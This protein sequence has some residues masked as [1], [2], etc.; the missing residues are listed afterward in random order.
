MDTLH[1]TS[2]RRSADGDQP[3]HRVEL[4][5]PSG[6]TAVV[7]VVGEHDLSRA[8]ALRDALV[9]AAEQRSQVLVDFSRCTLLDSTGIALLLEAQLQVRAAEGRFV[10]VIPPEQRAVARVAELIRLAD[11]VPVAQTLDEALAHLDRPLNGNSAAS[12]DG[13]RPAR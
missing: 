2:R 9:T 10:L 12:I 13:M 1:N 6:T 4:A 5:Y 8:D 3:A 7:S 11:L